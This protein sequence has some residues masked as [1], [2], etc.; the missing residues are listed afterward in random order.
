MFS[1][2]GSPLTA[3]RTAVAAK[4]LALAALAA[5]SG[6]AMGMLALLARLLGQQPHLCVLLEH[7]SSNPPGQLPKLYAQN[8]T[9]ISHVI[10][11]AFCTND[12]KAFILRTFLCSLGCD[13]SRAGCRCHVAS[14]C[15]LSLSRPE[16]LQTQRPS[17]LILDI[18][19]CDAASTSPSRF[20]SRQLLLKIFAKQSSGHTAPSA[21]SCSDT[22]ISENHCVLMDP[23]LPSP[24]AWCAQMHQALSCFC[25]HPSSKWPSHLFKSSRRKVHNSPTGASPAEAMNSGP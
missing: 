18:Q 1:G 7:E 13:V 23:P 22:P 14:A 16:A 3:K 24:P 9:A 19:S 6:G 21:L 20:V 5:D 10:L 25:I 4:H 8:A 12:S 15:I 17:P 11:R 2:H